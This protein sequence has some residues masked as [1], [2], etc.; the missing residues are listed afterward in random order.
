[1]REAGKTIR[2]EDVVLMRRNTAFIKTGKRKGQ[3]QV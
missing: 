1:M 2:V 3:I